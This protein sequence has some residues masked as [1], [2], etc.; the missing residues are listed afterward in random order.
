MC[1]RIAFTFPLWLLFLNTTLTAQSISI[2]AQSGDIVPDQD[3]VFGNLSAPLLGDSGGVSFFSTVNGDNGDYDGLFVFS[4]GLN[5]TVARQGVLAP[6]TTAEY[7]TFPFSSRGV[8]DSGNL[9]FRSN[10]TGGD[11]GQG[12]FVGNAIATLAIAVQN[13]PSPGGP[14]FFNFGTPSINE[15]NRVV[16]EGCLTLSLYESTPSGG[17]S[18]LLSDGDATPAGGTFAAFGRPL[19]NEL[20]QV[21]FYADADVAG[22]TGIFLLNTNGLIAVATELQGVPNSDVSIETLSQFPALNNSGELAFQ[23][24]LSDG[25]TGIFRYNGFFATL[26]ARSGDPVPSGD[27]VF[28]T[29]GSA[30][31]PLINDQGQIV[32]QCDVEGTSTQNDAGIFMAQ[33]GTNV[34]VI[35]VGTAVEGGA[36]AAFDDIATNLNGQIAFTADLDVGSSLPLEAIFLQCPELGLVEAIRQTDTL[37]GSTV[38]SLSFPTGMQHNGDEKSGFNNVGQ[39]AFNTALED[40]RE[41][42]AIWS[43]PIVLGD[44]N[45]DCIVSLLDVGP[46]VD[47]LQGNEFNPAADINGD[48]VISLLDVG[49]FVDLLTGQ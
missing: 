25:T 18:E 22:A 17:V 32:F 33:D 14:D 6:T 23:A 49:P 4:S 13:D 28:G 46:F 45:S 37:L 2:V 9:V 38:E 47:L 5:R 34:E 39:I 1:L 24:D 48:G 42:I 16:F 43:P 41:A 12:V 19:V 26:V 35:R 29:F 7:S 31:L 20:D 10:L 44:L 40:A 30:N 36:I 21:A 15:A 8:N 27:G 3:G 11:S